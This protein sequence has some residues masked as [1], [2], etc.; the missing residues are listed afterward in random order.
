MKHHLG[1]PLDQRDQAT[2]Q[3]QREDFDRADI[4][5]SEKRIR[6]DAGIN[7]NATKWRYSRPDNRAR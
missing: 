5:R 2:R 7:S 4:E 1:T 6:Q 3:K